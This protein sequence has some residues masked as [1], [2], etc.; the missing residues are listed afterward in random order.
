MRNKTFE[1]TLSRA[2]KAVSPAIS[3]VII[4]AVTVVLVVTASQF[5]Y[6]TLD[7]QQ[8]ASELDTI[9]KSII[10]F[11]DALRDIAWSRQGARSAHFT[12][13]YGR[14]EVAPS[15]LP[16]M[17]NVIEY[18]VSYS[19]STGYLQYSIS[20]DYVNYGNGYISYIFGDNRSVLPAGTA[21]L[22]QA[23]VK[24]E[25]G[26]VT[27]LLNYRVR[28]VLEGPA[29]LV[30]SKLVNYVDILIISVY[31]PKRIQYSGDFDLVA[32]NLYVTTDSS[33]PYSLIGDTCT[34]SVDLCGAVSSVLVSLEPN[35]DEVVFNFITAKVQITT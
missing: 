3:T 13:N 29:T 33:G 17:I 24:Q 27:V 35:S 12:V 31:V 5:A 15:T 28:A 7:R 25:G 23:L 16:L 11:D 26:Q 8:G 9:E 21:S 18:P 19:T 22:G 10:A 32:K 1:N 20:T 30:D 4:T 2:R 6:Q 14:L 34:V